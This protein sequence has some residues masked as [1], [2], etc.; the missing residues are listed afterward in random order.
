MQEKN[1]FS[2]KLTSTETKLLAKALIKY[3]NDESANYPDCDTVTAFQKTSVPE[4]K[5]EEWGQ[6]VG[7]AYDS[8]GYDDSAIEMEVGK[9]VSPSEFKRKFEQWQ[10]A[11]S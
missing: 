7:L 9:S 11:R 6:I 4:P 3:A 5:D 10:Q 8:T 2:G 1:K